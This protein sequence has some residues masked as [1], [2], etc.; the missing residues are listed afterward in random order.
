MKVFKLLVIMF[1]IS[2]V[3]LSG[4]FIVYMIQSDPEIQYA[5]GDTAPSSKAI[6]LIEGETEATNVFEDIHEENDG[7]AEWLP[8]PDP[9]QFEEETNQGEKIEQSD[10][11]G[12][13]EYFEPENP[14][15]V[16]ERI[17]YN[18]DGT[19][20]I[21]RKPGTE[22]ERTI[23]GTFGSNLMKIKVSSYTPM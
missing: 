15:E 11:Y 18:R 10:I 12:T 1:A 22:Y 14:E 17:T 4:A 7:D 5:T 9:S 21:I 20:E 8:D 16:I 2:A 19:T 6:S 13:W 23:T 3:V